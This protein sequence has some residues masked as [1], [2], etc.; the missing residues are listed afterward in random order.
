MAGEK[1]HGRYDVR[2]ITFFPFTGQCFRAKWGLWFVIAYWFVLAVVNI[3]GILPENT[4]RWWKASGVDF[5]QYYAGAVAAKEKLWRFLYPVNLVAY[6][7]PRN[8]DYAADLD[9]AL[10]L[11]GATTRTK[12]IYPPPTA[13]LMLPF[14]CFDFTLSLRLFIALLWLVS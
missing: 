9:K 4:P 7:T 14:S 8:A 2:R 13:L 5:D 11:R 12:N 3:S 1:N 6:E 10:S